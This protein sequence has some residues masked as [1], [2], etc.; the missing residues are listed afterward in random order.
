M[1]EI[2]NFRR[3]KKAKA[4]AGKEQRAGENRAKF[5][6]SKSSKVLKDARDA[7]D[8][9]KIDAHKRDDQT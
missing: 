3:A 8:R 2:V 6:T 5:G 4:R 1:A 9:R 7:L